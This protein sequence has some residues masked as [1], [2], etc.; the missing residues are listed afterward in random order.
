MLHFDWVHKM[1][2][3]IGA[4]NMADERIWEAWKDEGKMKCIIN[5]N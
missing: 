3:L 2:G 5:E 1:K 4:T